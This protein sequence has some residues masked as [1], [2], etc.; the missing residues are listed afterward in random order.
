MIKLQHYLEESIYDILDLIHD[1][2]LFIDHN[3]NLARKK[4]IISAISGAG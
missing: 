1:F 3:G 2:V 4:V